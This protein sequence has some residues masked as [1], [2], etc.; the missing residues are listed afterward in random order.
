[1]DVRKIELCRRGGG[2]KGDIEKLRGRG[3]G[4]DG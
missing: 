4:M 1:M 3:C 2:E